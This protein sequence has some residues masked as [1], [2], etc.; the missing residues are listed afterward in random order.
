MIKFFALQTIPA[1]GALAAAE[2]ITLAPVIEFRRNQLIAPSTKS[3]K[4]NNNIHVDTPANQ[5]QNGQRH[6]PASPTSD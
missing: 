3:S 1:T 5:S 6:K 2:K 4:N